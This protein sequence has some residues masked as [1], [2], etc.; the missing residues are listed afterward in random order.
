MDISSR[1]TKRI[2]L[3]DNDS[4]SSFNNNTAQQNHGVYQVFYNLLEEIR[5]TQILEIGTALG[6]FTQFLD[7]CRE[8]LNID[9]RILSYDISER[10]WYKDIIKDRL[11]IRVEDIFTEAYT[12]VN[13]YTKNFIASEGVTIILCDGGDKI[14]E[15]KLLAKFLKEGDYIMAHD[16]A[17]NKEIFDTTIYGKVW[18]WLEITDKDI[19]ESVRDNGLER[20]KRDELSQVAW[21]AFKKV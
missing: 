1:V 8:E 15:F 7:F 5:P 19:E 9:S 14:S 17:D 4:L 21:V 11:D 20:Y 18:N 3:G 12:D 13:S 2:E 6:G 16:Y 10:P